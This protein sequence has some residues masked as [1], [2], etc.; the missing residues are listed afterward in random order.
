MNTIIRN[1]FPVVAAVALSAVIVVGFA[2]TFYLRALFDVPPL[3]LAAW[4]H[5]VLS[6]AWLLLHYSQAKLIAA[7]RVD[8]HKRL[9]IVAACVG[10]VSAIQAF[11]LAILGVAAGKA[12]PG[13]DPLQFLSVPMGTTLIFLSFLTLALVMRRRRDWHKRL[14]FFATLALI[15]PA[16]GRIDLLFGSQLGLPRASLPLI[17][18][19]AFI[20][21]AWWND[22][23]KTGRVHPAYLYGGILLAVS[24]P[25]RRWIGMQDGWRPIAEWLVS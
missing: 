15:V 20:A 10:F 7:H 11:Q 3:T 21:W 24:V 12:P 19:V 9:G 23:R 22:W 6:T 17:V 18:T 13:R 5:G 4:L 16:V 2:R 14:M 1:R 25:L 8:V